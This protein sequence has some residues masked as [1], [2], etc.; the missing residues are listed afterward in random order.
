MNGGSLGRVSRFGGVG[1]SIQ[2]V[3]HLALLVASLLYGS[4]SE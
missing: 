1:S 3:T 2:A 4:F